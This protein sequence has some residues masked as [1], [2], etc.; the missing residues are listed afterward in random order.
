MTDQTYY[1]PEGLPAPAPLRDG[2]DTEYWD[3]LKRG[4][5]VVQRC[6]SCRA[7]QW[8]PE[9]ICHKCLSFDM[10]WEA[11][12]PKGILYSH[13]RVWH[14]VHNALQTHGP[15]VV[16]LVELPHADGIRVIGN[17]LGDPQQE[18]VI[19]SPVTGQ[20]EQHGA[21]DDAYMLLQWRLAS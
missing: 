9:W 13:Q 1:L 15:Y 21:G 3:G 18:L 12:E 20:F 6:N 11:V 19:G 16:A 10:G 17:L 7:F 4:E 2:L 5:L 8:G 14:P